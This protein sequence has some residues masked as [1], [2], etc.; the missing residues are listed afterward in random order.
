MTAHPAPI[1]SAQAQA[2]E[3]LPL[4]Y[5][6]LRRLARSYLGGD[7]RT[8]APTALVH[9]AYLRLEGRNFR[10]RSHFFAV[11]AKALRQVLVDYARARGRLKRAG[12]Q[13]RVD[14][15]EGLMGAAAALPPEDLL[16]LDQAL[17]RLGEVSPR[18]ARVVEL[19]YFGGLSVPETAR[20]M[21]LS[22]RTVEGDWTFAKAWLRRQL[23]GSF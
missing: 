10:D 22:L 14:F 12:G 5:D 11:S 6:Q 13:T 7:G 19:R 3:L 2:E 1:T 15:D 4:V 20:E 16:A 21:D 23:E 17:S 9:E 8:L 18:Q